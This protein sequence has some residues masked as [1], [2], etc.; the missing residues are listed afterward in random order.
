MWLLMLFQHSAEGILWNDRVVWE[1]DEDV[2]AARA[3]RHIPADKRANGSEH[4]SVSCMLVIPHLVNHV[5]Y[6]NVC[7]VFALFFDDA[8][9]K[10]VNR[11]P[12]T[13]GFNHDS[14]VVLNG[15]DII[16]SLGHS[17]DIYSDN[18]NGTAEISLAEIG[19]L[20][21]GFRQIDSLACS[22]VVQPNF[23]QPNQ[24]FQ[25]FSS[26]LGLLYKLSISR[27]FLG[28]SAL[29]LARGR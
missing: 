7:G 16:A 1:H 15:I 22:G 26:H 29:R 8:R 5:T 4:G 11:P 13:S 17:R 10:R 20:Q 3:G 25:F 18:P 2:G 9:T 28:S 24:A 19:A 21:I 23:M 6:K 12:P 27:G 14:C